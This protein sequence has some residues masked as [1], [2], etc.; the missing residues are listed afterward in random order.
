MYSVCKLKKINILGM[1]KVS[2][3]LY[4]CGKDMAKKSNLQHWNNSHFKNWIIVALCALKNDIYIV[5]DEN[6]N[7]LATF[8]IRKVNDSL[9][10]QK[11]ATTPAYAKSGIGSFC[12]KEIENIGKSK[13]CT[14]IICEVY[15]KSE[16]AK[17]F[18]ENR[19]YAIYGTTDTLRYRE[20][21]FKK[22]I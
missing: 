13:G 20:L 5:Y 6:S 12:L 21:K 7:V 11:L 18:Y 10:F 8:Q 15:E 17:K 22:D 14:E 4:K 3:I 9:L 19:G 1:L 2:D 16:N